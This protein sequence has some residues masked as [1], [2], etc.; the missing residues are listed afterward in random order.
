[1]AKWLKT[2]GVFVQADIKRAQ[3]NVKQAAD[4]ASVGDK[5]TWMKILAR[6]GYAA[7][8][9]VYLIIGVLAVEGGVAGGSRSALIQINQQPFGRVLLTLV[10]IGLLAYAIWRFVHGITDPENEGDDAKALAKRAGYVASGVVYGA[11]AFS[12]AQIA[13]GNGGGNGAQHWTAEVLD[14]AF[15][16][17]L[18]GLAG[19]G[20]I[21]G[22]LHQLQQA[23]TAKFKEDFA[24]SEIN[25]EQ[26][27]WAV[28]AGRAGHAARTVVYLIIGWFLMQAALT[29]SSSEVGGLGEALSTL[30]QQ[31]Y[32]RWLLGA[33]GVGLV[34][35]GIYCFVLA[36]YRKAVY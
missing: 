2:R 24:L 5:A 12:A 18:V 33:A 26:E 31:P 27:R 9:V 4:Q 7:K 34:C 8:G 28:R 10:A 13:F 25:P 14:L 36:R 21:L 19:V 29:Y 32:G 35:Y 11:L 20:V 1:M 30:Q 3:R 16:R 22:G 23:I 6:L 15:G 17:W